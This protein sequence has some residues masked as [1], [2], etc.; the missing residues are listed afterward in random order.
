MPYPNLAQSNSRARAS[1]FAQRETSCVAPARVLLHPRHE[2][3]P[4]LQLVMQD[5]PLIRQLV[6]EGRREPFQSPCQKVR[7]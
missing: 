4:A 6:C 7:Q 1:A 3:L 2:K 5:A